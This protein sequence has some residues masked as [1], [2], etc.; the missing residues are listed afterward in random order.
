MSKALHATMW[1][2]L[3]VVGTRWGHYLGSQLRRFY[4]GDLAI[5]G[6]DLTRARRIGK[7][8][9]AATYLQGW[10]QA[11]ASPDVSAVILAIPPHLHARAAIAAAET[12]KHVFVEKPLATSVE[13]AD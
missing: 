5:A 1:A 12:G 13:E 8:L 6:N 11:V 9:G 7:T 2:M 10:E 3:C 4:H